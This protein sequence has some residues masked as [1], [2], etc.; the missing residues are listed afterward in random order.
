MTIWL[1]VLAVLASVAAMGYRQGAIRAGISFF[2]IIF[3][4]VSALLLG[5]ITGKLLLRFGVDNLLAIWLV[6]PL[7]VF[8]IVSIIFKS[9]AAAVHHKVDVY[10]KY[11]AGDLRQALWERLNHRLGACLGLLNGAAYAIL[12]SF[13]LYLSGYC[14]H[15]FAT[16]DEDPRWI[17]VLDTLGK[18]LHK[19]GF[20][21]VGR[22][23]DRVDPLKYEMM[24]FAG[25]LYHNPQAQARISRYPGFLSLA[26][27]Q[28]FQSL[29]NDAAFTD[30]WMRKAPIM[31][32]LENPNALAIRANQPFLST[33]WETTVPVLH[34]FTNYLATANSAQ[35]DSEKLLGRWV[36]D[37]NPTI[38]AVRRAKPLM[39]SPEMQRIKQRIQADYANATMVAMPDSRIVLK[40]LAPSPGAQPQ[41]L[42]GQWKKTDGKYQLSIG[43]RDDLISIE[44]ERFF[45]KRDGME[46]AFTREL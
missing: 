14:V 36:F 19:T 30:S 33:I 7:I 26:E 11:R 21:K 8:V 20:A 1:L 3:G 22:A 9:L 13:V 27:K 39:S 18:D 25:L 44:N 42:E 6:G 41:N 34:D 37:P 28:E 5:P 43:G 32:L 45:L 40:N 12:L 46:L 4:A 29:G 38:N 2:G 16:S 35:F 23:L 31:N 15:Q 10:Y 24:D 17:R